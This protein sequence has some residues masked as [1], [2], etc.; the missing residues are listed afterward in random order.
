MASIEGKRTPTKSFA[1]LTTPAVVPK[2]EANAPSPKTPSK[3]NVNVVLDP[4]DASNPELATPMEALVRAHDWS[5]ATVHI[6]RTRFKD[7]YNRTLLF[8]G[9]NLSG[10]S[11]LPTSPPGSTHL[12]EGFFNHRNVSFIGRPFPLEDADEHL[13]RLRAWGLTFVRLLVTWEA[14]EHSGPGIYDEDF[15]L[16]LRRVCQK[17]H[18]FGMKCFIDPHQDCVSMIFD[19]NI[20]IS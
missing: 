11:K 6:S 3:V 8:R 4:A 7:Q 12:S 19:I 16:Y 1:T 17:I 20:K 18:D 13:G 2:Q 9:V 10:M 14:L 15:I 5:H